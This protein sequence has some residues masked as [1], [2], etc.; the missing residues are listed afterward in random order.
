MQQSVIPAQT[1]RF[2]LLAELV[3]AFA[4]VFVWVTVTAADF[5]YPQKLGIVGKAIAVGA[6]VAVAS[7]ANAWRSGALG[8]PAIVLA[9]V[10]VGRLKPWRAALLILA[11][12]AGAIAGAGIAR[13]MFASGPLAIARGATPIWHP[14]LNE[15][16]ALAFE[17]ACG[18][19]LMWSLL[20]TNRRRTASQP[21]AARIH[22]DQQFDSDS[23]THSAAAEAAGRLLEPRFWRSPNW[24]GVF[25]GLCSLIFALIGSNISRGIA[26]PIIA[27]GPAATSMFWDSQFPYWVGPT[28]ASV[29]A[30]VA[31]NV[32]Y[33]PSGVKGTSSEG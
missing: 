28:L 4:L 7:A 10:S 5:A 13:G 25:A 6:M 26:N 17:F 16:H 2:S 9:F 31:I 30:S 12:L 33:R 20:E 21:D 14:R 27:F 19:I 32:I 11:Q 23:R 29:L 22:A 3:T 18:L 1:F 15:Y 8:N 24:V